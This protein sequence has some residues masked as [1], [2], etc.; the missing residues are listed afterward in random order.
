MYKMRM[1]NWMLF[2][3]LVVLSIIWG[4]VYWMFIAD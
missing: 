2:I 4:L 1:K 3:V